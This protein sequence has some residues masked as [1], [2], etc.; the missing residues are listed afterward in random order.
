MRLPGSFAIEYGWGHQRLD[1][2]RHQPTIYQA[3]TPVDIWSGRVQSEDF[4]LG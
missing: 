2:A 3:G 4:V 1:D